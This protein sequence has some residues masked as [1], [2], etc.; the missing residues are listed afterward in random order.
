M[1]QHTA[2]AAKAA[3]AAASFSCPS[4]GA[5]PAVGSGASF[6]QIVIDQ[7]RADVNKLCGLRVDFQPN[8]STA[9]RTNF[10]N[11][12]VDF[13][14]SDIQ[15]SKSELQGLKRAF[16]YVPITAGG[17]GMMYNL[18][19][20]AGRRVTDLRLSPN[21]ACKIFTGQITSWN[22]PQITADNNGRA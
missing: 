21:S 15:F 7:W 10:I 22:D 6:P 13:G 12:A 2:A 14:V 20:A 3:V 4:A 17:L 19:D 1:L 11:N 18:K 8:G 9:G 5:S 16:V